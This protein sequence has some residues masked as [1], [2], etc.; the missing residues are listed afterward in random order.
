M[1]SLQERYLTDDQGNRIGVL[2]DIAAYQQ[3]LD[4]LEELESLY[5][6]D[7][8]VASEDESMPLEDAIMEIEAQ[9]TS[10]P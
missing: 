6:F 3:L 2:L 9:R 7:Q 1:D 4:K 5:A 8:A 10:S